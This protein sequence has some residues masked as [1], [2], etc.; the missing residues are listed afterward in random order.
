MT[1]EIK[2]IID[3]FVADKEY[4]WERYVGDVITSKR[5]GDNELVLLCRYTNDKEQVQAYCFT[6]LKKGG[7]VYESREIYE[8]DSNDFS[9][10]DNIYELIDDNTNILEWESKY[11]N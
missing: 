7:L 1:E 5:M 9:Y 4:K 10:I 2:G 6:I 11:E 3:R 8:D